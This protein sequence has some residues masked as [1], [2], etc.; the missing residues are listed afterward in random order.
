MKWILAG[1]DS[2]DSFILAFESQVLGYAI[3]NF[4]IL[5]QDL[6][7]RMVTTHGDISLIP[8]VEIA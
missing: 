7:S 3:V 6:P 2:P 5:P 1:G 4:D 8:T